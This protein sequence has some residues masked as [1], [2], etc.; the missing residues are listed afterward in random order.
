M[1]PI[2]ITR[3]DGG[4]SFL[5]PV[6][7]DFNADAEIEKWKGVNP[8]QYV[9]H[10]E[11]EPG[12]IPQDRTFRNAWKPD[13]SHDMAKA[14]DMQRERMRETRKPMLAALDVEYQRA[15]ESGDA[16]A[17]RAIAKRKQE[18]RDVTAHPDIEAAD[19]TEKLKAVWPKALKEK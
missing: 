7:D 14:R 18:L 10:R 8:G 13:F 3:A 19:T 9:S 11:V 16:T 17:K 2:T 1:K 15:D 12:K 5:I 4:V 6:K